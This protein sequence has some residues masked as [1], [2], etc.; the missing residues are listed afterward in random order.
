MR[1]MIWVIF[2]AAAFARVVEAQPCA[3]NF[4]DWVKASNAFGWKYFSAKAKSDPTQNIIVSPPS[5]GTSL[6][7]LL[8]GGS[9]QAQ[10]E[11]AGALGLENVEW[12]VSGMTK[13]FEGLGN[14]VIVRT[15]NSLWTD[16][17]FTISP[18]YLD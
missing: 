2:I 17:G 3:A 12:I 13:N 4:P 9:S 18:T 15:A 11:I 1:K 6:Q 7:M 8:L 10:S 16:S 14:G 5:L